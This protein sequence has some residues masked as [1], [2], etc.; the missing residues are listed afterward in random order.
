VTTGTPAQ[1][2]RRT[3]AT[4]LAA[5]TISALPV[6]LLGGL[7]LLVRADL[8]FG[9]LGLG[10]A[11]GAFFTASALVSLPAGAVSDRV[12]PVQTMALGLV[13]TAGT[14]VGVAV[15]P[16]SLGGL[17]PWLVVGGIANAFIQVGAN[18][19]LAVDVPRRQ[20]GIAYGV[21]QSAV[22]LAAVLAGLSVPAIGL[23]VGWRAAY[24]AA[25]LV[26]L[27]VLWTI[28]RG[29][30]GQERE[31]T[32]AERSADAPRLA[33]VVLALGAAFGTT[34]ANALA[35]FSVSSSVDAG[36]AQDVAGLLLTAGSLLGMASRIGSGWVA[37]RIGWGSLLLAAGL[38]AIGAVGY[39]GMAAR[40]PAI[41]LVPMTLLA[42]M[43]G[44]GYQGLVLLAVARTNPGA[45]ASAMA[46][47][48]IGPNTGAV[49]G[50]LAFG[51]L[52]EAAGYQ[53]A[54]AFAAG[55]SLAAVILVLL[56]RVML[57]P[58]RERIAAARDAETESG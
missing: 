15:L 26:G 56:G 25:A 48:R 55:A 46:I 1:P 12:G 31:D 36:M 18:H 4:T 29:V 37:D 33:L 43:G 28:W 9:E 22:P 38:L 24:A 16:T 23:T 30:R 35:G 21:K 40:P 58:V 39:A 49:V 8:H 10:I 17:L 20:Q 47:V 50:P 2:L 52:V 57:V 42:F 51:A 7:A 44:W 27:V 32:T 13:L 41:A 53:V 45:P 3:L 14:L 19:L 6:L 54:W 11:I 5:A 34:A